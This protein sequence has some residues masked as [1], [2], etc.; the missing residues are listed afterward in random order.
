MYS[1][2]LCHRCNFSALLS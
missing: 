2:K 1:S